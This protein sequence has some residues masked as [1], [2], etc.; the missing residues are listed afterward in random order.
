MDKQPQKTPT[1]RTPTREMRHRAAFVLFVVAVLFFLANIATLCRLQLVEGEDWQKR[2]VSQ[3][4]SDTVVTAKRGPI[5]DANMQP[6]AESA[7]VWKIIM[8]PKNIAA[9]NWKRLEELIL[10]TVMKFVVST[11]LAVIIV[12]EALLK[13]TELVRKKLMLHLYLWSMPILSS[14]LIIL[15]H[16]SLVMKLRLHSRCMELLRELD[17]CLCLKVIALQLLGFV[18]FLLIASLMDGCIIVLYDMQMH[19][20]IG[21]MYLALVALF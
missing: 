6:L 16:L 3:Q 18:G 5:Y 20:M 11:Y 9:C 7:D 17:I 13:A 1:T 19:S 10:S 12:T 21:A 4:M 8:S 15:Q 2:A 14:L